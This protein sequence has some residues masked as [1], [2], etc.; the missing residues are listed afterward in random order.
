MGH[1]A[2]TPLE[3]ALKYR[4]FGW[5]VIPFR[6]GTKRPM[7]RW[8]Q[9]QTARPSEDTLRRWFADHPDANLGIVTGR[10]SDLVVLDIDPKFGGDDSLIELEH[11]HGPLPETPE[12][13]TGGGGRHLYFR[14]P[15]GELRNRVNLLPGI[16]L[17]GDGGVI[18]APPSI[19]P[20]GRPYVWEVSHHPDDVKIS[21]MP[22]WLHAIVTGI[23][24][25]TGHT[26]EYW[27]DLLRTGV[28]EGARNQT[29]A[30]LAGHLFWHRVDPRIIQE[31]LLAWNQ[32]RCRPPLEENEVAAVVRNIERLHIEDPGGSASS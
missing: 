32:A 17:R 28:N 8:R 12:V 24:E 20:S 4:S 9:F 13:L 23:G 31:L 21:E 19:H 15:G 14:H 16:D 6:A 11:R 30:S 27:Q 1:S 29:L 2:T 25:R 26:V 5:S 3:A 7:V 22:G 10:V 18:V